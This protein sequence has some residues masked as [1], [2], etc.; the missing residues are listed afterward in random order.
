MVKA[1]RERKKEESRWQDRNRNMEDIVN[2]GDGFKEKEDNSN[3]RIYQAVKPGNKWLRKDIG[4]SVEE[5]YVWSLREL[6][7][8]LKCPVTSAFMSPGSLFSAH[9]SSTRIAATHMPEL[10]LV[11]VLIHSM[12][13]APLSFR[14]QAHLVNPSAEQEK[15][16]LGVMI[17]RE[18]WEG[19]VVSLNKKSV[20]SVASSF[21]WYP[22]EFTVCGFRHFWMQRG[23][24][25]LSQSQVLCIRQ[26]L[27]LSYL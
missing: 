12:W 24:W 13:E 11:T 27:K 21:C 9:I 7:A 18:L 1:K 8:N 26:A 19:N 17:G 3:Y 22:S 2:M 14:G 23:P 25:R 16:G 10:C 15:V 4:T 6:M 5:G 20:I